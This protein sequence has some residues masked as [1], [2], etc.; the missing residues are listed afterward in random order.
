LREQRIELPPATIEVTCRNSGVTV[1][2]FQHGA[3]GQR[4]PRPLTWNPVAAVAEAM[5]VELMIVR[6]A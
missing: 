3:D 5:A 4:L 2:D 1:R 6:G